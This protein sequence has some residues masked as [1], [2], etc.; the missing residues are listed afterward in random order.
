MRAT[1]HSDYLLS[2]FR[3][4]ASNFH[5]SVPPSGTVSVDPEFKVGGVYHDFRVKIVGSASC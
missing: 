1:G 3:G 2:S 5:G 4:T